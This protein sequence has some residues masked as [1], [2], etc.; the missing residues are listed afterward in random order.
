MATLFLIALCFVSCFI[1]LFC[2]KQN[3]IWGKWIFKITASSAFVLIALALADASSLFSN[4]MLVGFGFSFL[5]D[6]FLIKSN[7]STFFKIG[8]ISFAFAHIAFIVAFLTIG[9]TG[10]VFFITTILTMFL[11]MMSVKWLKNALNSEFKVL[12][13]VYICIIAYMTSLSGYAWEGSYRNGI[14]PGAFLFAVSDLFVAREKFIKS[15]FKN[16]M[17]GLPLYYLAQIFL[18][19]SLDW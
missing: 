14:L 19:I 4:L 17:V 11:I 5:G 13:L 10:L 2:E 16:K 12:V 7:E 18:A 6:I 1:L 3:S 9:S 15:D 8:I